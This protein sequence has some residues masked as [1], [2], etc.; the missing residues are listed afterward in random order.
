MPSDRLQVTSDEL[1]RDQIRDYLA[2]CRDGTHVRWNGACWLVWHHTTEYGSN[3]RHTFE[4]HRA[5][6]ADCDS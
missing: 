6:D 5:D 2:A 1:D 3:L 4:L